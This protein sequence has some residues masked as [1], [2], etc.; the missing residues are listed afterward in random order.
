M[1]RALA[2]Q[3]LAILFDHGCDDPFH[4]LKVVVVRHPQAKRIQT[5]H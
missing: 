1:P 5:R 3:Q 4:N 2:D